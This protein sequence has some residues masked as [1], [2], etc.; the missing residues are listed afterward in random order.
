MG[1][2]TAIK[3]DGSVITWGNSINGGEMKDS[4]SSELTSDVKKIYSTTHAFAALKDDNTI[5]TWGLDYLYG[6][7]IKPKAKLL[8]T[9]K[10]IVA[11]SGAYAALKED[12]SVVTWGNIDS[13]GDTSYMPDAKN[14]STGVVDIFTAGS[15][16][17]AL[18]EDGSV[19]TWG[20]VSEDTIVLEKDICISNIYNKCEN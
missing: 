15:S 10:D 1:A 13:G 17:V 9:I 19:V 11:N 8:G 7:A 3:K 2:F 6:T 20:D 5:V 16:F 18:K 12:G 4:I 14:I